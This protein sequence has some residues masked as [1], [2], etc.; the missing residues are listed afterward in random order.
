VTTPREASVLAATLRRV[1]LL[2]GEG[3]PLRVEKQHASVW[4]KVG[5]PDLDGCLAGRALKIEV[6]RLGAKPTPIQKKALHD[7]RR[8]GAIA[9]WS[10]TPGV[11]EEELRAV[12]AKVS[13]GPVDLRLPWMPTLDLL[14]RQI[15]IEDTELGLGGKTRC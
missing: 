5:R 12:W 14:R 7:W 1:T 15:E 3:V 9:F 2:I 10:D 4:A 11:I 6:K 8:A 13:A